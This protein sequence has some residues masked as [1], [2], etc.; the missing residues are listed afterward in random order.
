MK[1]SKP[2]FQIQ[3]VRGTFGM[4]SQE[5]SEECTAVA[6]S[7]SI[8]SVVTTQQYTLVPTDSAEMVKAI[9][10]SAKN[11]VAGDLSLVEGMMVKQLHVL[12]A[13]FTNLSMKAS[14]Q[15]YAKNMETL[16]RLALKA[17]SQARCTAEALA[18]MKN[19]M[20]YIKQANI[21]H[22]HQQVNNG[23]AAISEHYAPVHAHAGEVRTA[24]SK[25]LQEVRP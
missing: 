24:P 10:K 22:G 1:K 25:L 5:T 20:P 4:E 12:D 15:D 8:Q 9:D 16:L 19:P 17:Q 18:L 11:V 21:A 7:H 23:Q 14:T 13:M 2:A 6:V 3:A